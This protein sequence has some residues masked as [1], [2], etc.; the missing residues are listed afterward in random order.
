MELLNFISAQVVLS[1]ERKINEE[2]LNNQAAR[3]QSIFDSSNHIIWSIDNGLRIT[4]FNRNFEYEMLKNF[5]IKPVPDTQLKGKHIFD[6]L[7]DNQKNSGKIS[8]I[9]HWTDEHK[10][11]ELKFI[12]PDSSKII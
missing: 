2:K 4:S 6:K 1:V 8:L 9:L 11:F 12:D 5:N 7:S 3:L 10:N